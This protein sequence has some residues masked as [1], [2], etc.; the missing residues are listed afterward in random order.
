MF[1]ITLVK[2]GVEKT[3][4]KA[5]I[6]VE[7]NLLAVE[8]QV[9]QSAIYNDKKAMFNPKKHREL[10][11]EYLKMFVKM[12]GEQ[13]T[14]DDLKSSNMSVLNTLNELFIEA[15]GGK[16]EEGDEKKEQ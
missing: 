9:R 1:E 12:Y 14:V 15:L 7:D 4:S 2:G 8:H 5:F 6:N 10:N 16:S 3:Y 11:E 13:F